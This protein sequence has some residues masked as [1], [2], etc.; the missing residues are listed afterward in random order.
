[1]SSN[2]RVLT[3]NASS[4]FLKLN[5]TLSALNQNITNLTSTVVGQNTQKKQKKRTV[6][7]SSDERSSPSLVDEESVDELVAQ[8]PTLSVSAKKSK[9]VSAYNVPVEEPMATTTSSSSS[10]NEMPTN[11]E[12][13][14]N[15]GVASLTLVSANDFNRHLQTLK[16]QSSNFHIYTRG[17]T[18]KQTTEQFSREYQTELCEKFLKNSLKVNERNTYHTHEIGSSYNNKSKLDKLQ[19]TVEDSPQNSLIVVSEISRL[20]RDAFQVFDVLKSAKENNC[21]ILSVIERL[22]FNVDRKMDTQ[23]YKKVIDSI[24]ESD[25]LSNRVIAAQNLIRQSGGYIGRAPYG[26]KSVKRTMPTGKTINILET[27]IEEQKA[28]NKIRA[29]YKANKNI[30]QTWALTVNYVSKNNLRPISKQ[31]MKKIVEG[32]VT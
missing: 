20:G 21:R 27:N 15:S 17:S 14:P 8:I 30:Q 18:P 7:E 29:F 2:R 28:M 1:M 26:K 6:E 22:I 24:E 10:A 19:C 11:N 9:K 23:F 12:F 31:L 4:H 3:V 5:R 16:S 32:Q 25:K 13:A